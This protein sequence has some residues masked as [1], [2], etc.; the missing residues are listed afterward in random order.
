MAV[1]GDEGRKLWRCRVACW[2]VLLSN[3]ASVSDS[4]SQK[5]GTWEVEKRFFEVNRE[6][7]G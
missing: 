5:G 7:R 6:I 2:I 3:S 1:D 4:G